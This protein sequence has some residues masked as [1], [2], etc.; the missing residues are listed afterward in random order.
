MCLVFPNS[1]PTD[2]GDLDLGGPEV[3]SLSP[4]G[5]LR[6]LPGG[7]RLLSRKLTTHP[8][9]FPRTGTMAHVYSLKNFLLCILNKKR[10]VNIALIKQVRATW[11]TSAWI[12]WED[13]LLFR[14]PSQ[15]LA[16]LQPP[17]PSHQ[18]PIST[19]RSASEKEWN[20]FL[21]GIGFKDLYQETC[22]NDYPYIGLEYDF[23]KTI[24]LII[25]RRSPAV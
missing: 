11:N 22:C 17:T 7:T 15:S 9:A 23:K 21:S 19:L 2:W 24:R 20:A 8:H 12:T 13:V 14:V 4:G 25:L 18:S 16:W 1:L 10:D 5:L 3:L 6:R